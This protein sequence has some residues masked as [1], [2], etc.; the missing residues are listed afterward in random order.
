MSAFK[1]R[2]AAN[3]APYSSAYSSAYKDSLLFG[4]TLPM[5]ALAL[6]V[7]SPVLILWSAIPIL[8]TFA[9]DLWLVLT[10]AH[11]IRE[12]IQQ[13]MGDATGLAILA[14]ILACVALLLASAL[15][16]SF[17]ACIIAAPLNDFLAEKAESLALPP[18]EPASLLPT[19]VRRR[20]RLIAIDL[21]KMM[22]AGTL[23]LLALTLSW[24][25]GINIAAIGVAWL[26]ISFEF[27]SYPQTRRGEGIGEGIRFIARNPLSC[28]GFGASCSFLF[29]IPLVSCFALPLAVVGGTLL[30]AQGHKR[31][32]LPPLPVDPESSD[33]PF[34]R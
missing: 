8:I 30:Y 10:A 9:L 21:T 34:R 7:S 27:I 20:T 33:Q 12:K 24:F 11:W 13:S 16:F 31:R 25:P 18:L 6:I 14:M 3:S 17:F 15:T 22:A 2:P 32:K 29:A 19:S 26:L 1:M 28:L 5:R 23:S 4:L